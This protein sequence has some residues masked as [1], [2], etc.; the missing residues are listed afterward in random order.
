M[1]VDDGDGDRAT[2]G[3]NVGKEKALKIVDMFLEPDMIKL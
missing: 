1:H 3:G 2:G